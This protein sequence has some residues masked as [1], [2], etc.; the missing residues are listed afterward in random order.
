MSE[1]TLSMPT[2]FEQV[3]E[4]HKMFNHPIASEPQLGV[5][6]KN[7]AL[8]QFRISQVEEE[9]AELTSA[10]DKKDFIECIDAICDLMYFVYGS[11]L[12]FGVDFDQYEPKPKVR[13]F[14]CPQNNTKI[15][16]TDTSAFQT[17]VTMLKQA[18]SLVT[19][20]AE[21]KDF[22]NMIKFF[23]KLET[24]C[25]SIST[26]LGVDINICFA[27][28]HRSNMTKLCLTEEIAV[29]TVTDYVQKK[30]TRDSL[31][32]ETEDE[33]E[34]A[35]IMEEYK[36][37]DDPDFKYDGTKYWIVYD[38]ATTKILKSVDFEKPRLAS[39]IGL[40]MTKHT[41][42]TQDEEKD[43]T[44]QCDDCDNCD[45]CDNCDEKQCQSN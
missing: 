3:R 7:P 25:R 29:R 1:Q 14:N 33:N 11:F 40:D 35:K 13:N 19:L 10:F 42:E 38:K 37:Y 9:F 44:K 31:L 24:I 4:F 34:R 20:S 41:Q 36:A 18:L 30:A 22:A 43:E 8:V 27:E 26:L 15:F 16:K 12:V 28:V 21:E 2:N 39:V 45:C 32:K 6:D 5:F 23:A 17:Q